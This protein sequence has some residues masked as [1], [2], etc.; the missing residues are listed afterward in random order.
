MGRTP[1]SQET[2]ALAS[3]TVYVCVCTYMGLEVNTGCIFQS[4]SSLFLRKNRWAAQKAQ[5]L[6]IIC[7]RISGLADLPAFLWGWWRFEPGFSSTLPSWV[8]STTATDTFN[9]YFIPKF[10]FYNPLI[11]R[12]R[13][14]AGTKSHCTEFS[15]KLSLDPN[16]TSFA[17]T[18]EQRHSEV[19][20]TRISSINT[21]CWLRHE[22]LFRRCTRILL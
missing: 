10:Q 9:D 14:N 21:A 22:Q 1:L 11:P 7:A 16:S 19:Q 4:F 17:L 13:S 12:K 15:F 18:G 5:G 2:L 3:H 20:G 8:I 6:W